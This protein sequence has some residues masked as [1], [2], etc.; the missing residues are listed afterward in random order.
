MIKI[1]L[2][3]LT[4][5]LFINSLL[6]IFIGIKEINNNNCFEIVYFTISFGMVLMAISIITAKTGGII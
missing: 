4:V 2:L 3:I 6:M 5:I 1:A